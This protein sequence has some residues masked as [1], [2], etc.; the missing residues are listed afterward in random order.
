MI[1]TLREFARFT[2]DRSGTLGRIAVVTSALIVVGL[3]VFLIPL[4]WRDTAA[5]ICFV[6]FPMTVVGLTALL[7]F[8]IGA[9]EDWLI[10]RGR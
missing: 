5:L 3:L 2:W 1:A 10:R 4:L 7:A 6:L 8:W 9:I